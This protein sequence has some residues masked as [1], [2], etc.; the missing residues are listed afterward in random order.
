M[1]VV[2]PPLFEK[3]KYLA[4]IYPTFPSAAAAQG[5]EAAASSA[6]GGALVCHSPVASRTF[7]PPAGVSVTI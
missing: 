4:A 3:P 2:S 7:T 6:G 5:E 1:V